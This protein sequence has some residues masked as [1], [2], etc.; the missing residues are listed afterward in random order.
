MARFG[1]LPLRSE[2]LALFELSLKGTDENAD[3]GQTITFDVGLTLRFE[4]DAFIV[5]DDNAEST[6]TY[7]FATLN[8]ALVEVL[9]SLAKP[10]RGGEV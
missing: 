3:G 8:E 10:I 9:S 6:S 4:D 2:L 7:A 1:T 5:W